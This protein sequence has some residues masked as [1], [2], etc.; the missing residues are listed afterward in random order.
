MGMKINH[1]KCG[2]M[3]FYKKKKTFS[4]GEKFE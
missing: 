2:I 1:E 3:P 4:D